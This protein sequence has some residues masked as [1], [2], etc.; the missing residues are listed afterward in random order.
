VRNI[1]QGWN[2][3]MTQDM[4]ELRNLV[5]WSYVLDSMKPKIILILSIFLLLACNLPSPAPAPDP[6]ATLPPEP[7]TSENMPGMIVRGQ[8]TINGV[9]LANVK[10][11]KRFSAYPHELIATTDEDGYYESDFIGIPGD[12]MVS[13]EAE[14]TG[15][16][17][18]PP[19]YY[20][21][22]YHGYE[23]TTCDFAASSEPSIR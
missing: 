21:R 1:S 22:H 19:Y 17:F 14:L 7:T 10:I 12:E 23:D 11:Y 20:W 9:G 13:I 4:H 2:E 5:M 6:T 8:V 16:T 3:K 15:Y 18:D